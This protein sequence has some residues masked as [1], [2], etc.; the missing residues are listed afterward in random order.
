MWDHFSLRFTLTCVF[1]V[2][3]KLFRFYNHFVRVRNPRGVGVVGKRNL[4]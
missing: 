4:Q 3:R 1:L 2:L